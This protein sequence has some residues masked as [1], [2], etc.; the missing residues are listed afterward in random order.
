[1]VLFKLFKGI[2][3]IIPD[4]IDFVQIQVASLGQEEYA[5]DVITSRCN[6]KG[7]L[8][9]EIDY[10]IKELEKIRKEGHKVLP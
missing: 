7:E 6:T 1:M 10:M 9:W 8:D 3:Q 5:E 2:D 4:R